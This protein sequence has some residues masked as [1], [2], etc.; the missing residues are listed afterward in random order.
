MIR[1][2]MDE[3]TRRSQRGRE[4][5]LEEDPTKVRNTSTHAIAIMVFRTVYLSYGLRLCDNAW[6][7]NIKA[8][9]LIR[10]H[11][12]RVNVY[13]PTKKHQK[14]NSAEHYY[15]KD[16]NLLNCLFCEN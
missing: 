3:V 14:Q 11:F 16:N 15:I 8:L 12:V 1:S 13:L 6:R 2:P 5:S 10:Y 9:I 7:I 4:Q